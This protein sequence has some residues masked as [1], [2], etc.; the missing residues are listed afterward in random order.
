MAKGTAATQQYDVR[1]ING[2]ESKGRYRVE[3]IMP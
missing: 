1:V 2:M 3:E